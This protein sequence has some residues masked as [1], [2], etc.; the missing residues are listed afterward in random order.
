[1]DNK[2]DEMQERKDRGAPGCAGHGE[3][4]AW[5]RSG[6]TRSGGNVFPRVTLAQAVLQ[7]GG[8]GRA[9]HGKVVSTRN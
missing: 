5:R 3:L 7:K 9:A 6:E 1:M 8:G 2:E 4:K